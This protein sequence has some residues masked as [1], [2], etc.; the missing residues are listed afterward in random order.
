MV[1]DYMRYTYFWIRKISDMEAGYI[2]L[3]YENRRDLE[4]YQDIVKGH[5]LSES[6]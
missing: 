2:H 6:D 5:K 1:S 3:A 4:H